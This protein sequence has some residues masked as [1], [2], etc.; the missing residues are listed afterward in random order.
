MLETKKNVKEQIRAVLSKN[1]ELLTDKS[2]IANILSDQFGSV[3][4][5]EPIM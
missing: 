1:N 3:F 5:V 4:V 2:D